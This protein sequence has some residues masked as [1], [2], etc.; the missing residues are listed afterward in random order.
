MGLMAGWGTMPPAS[1]GT[2][3]FVRPA[4]FPAWDENDFWT[5]LNPRSWCCSFLNHHNKVTLLLLGSD[6]QVAIPHSPPI[7]ECKT[8]IQE[9]GT[10][11]MDWDLE[12]K[13]A[14][15]FRVPY[16]SCSACFSLAK[17]RDKQLTYSWY[18][19][20]KSKDLKSTFFFF[21]YSIKISIIGL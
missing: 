19:S 16:R 14:T 10:G 12:Q 9:S 8:F 1:P 21:F 6:H 7:F 3:P 13:A 20:L 18:V 11:I 4:L 17:Q 15:L 2:L 5:V